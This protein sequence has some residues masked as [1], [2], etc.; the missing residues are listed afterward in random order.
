[1]KNKHEA[2]MTLIELMIA[3]AIGL[4]IALV[5]AS[6]YLSG[7]SAQQ[8]QTGTARAQEAARFAFD[9]IDLSLKKAGYKNPRVTADG[10][11]GSGVL[12]A[13]I[14]GINDA[15]GVSYSSSVTVLN[16]SDV[17]VVRYYGDTQNLA[18]YTSDNT[19]TDCLGNTYTANTL[20]ED[21]F[22]IAAD[23]VN[24]NEPA[25]W[26]DSQNG[27]THTGSAALVPGIESM[28]ILY[29]DDPTAVGIVTRY[30][31]ADA[32]LNFAN[33]RSAMVSFIARTKETSA[34]DTTVRNISHFGTDYAPASGDAHQF[35]TPADGRVRQHT[36]ATISMRNVCP[37]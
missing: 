20:I 28:Q 3:L 19:I 36:V 7:V 32:S 21:R 12:L 26:C 27:S 6:V 35:T 17:L 24:D 1:M 2:G 30:V 34:V 18:T 10:F 22:Y 23:P 37:L 11:C 29:G 14:D 13:R 5:A 4:L 33:V 15:T 9:L 8:A 31:K 16:S 25:L